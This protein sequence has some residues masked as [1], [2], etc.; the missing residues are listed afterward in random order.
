[1]TNHQDHLH[2]DTQKWPSEA[3][4]RL[5]AAW[6]VLRHGLPSQPAPETEE[7]SRTELLRLVKL[8]L[9]LTPVPPAWVD[10]ATTEELRTLAIAGAMALK[11]RESAWT[12][13]EAGGWPR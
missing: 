12:S 9:V 2:A 3:R 1:M 5:K 13:V 7:V 11:A 8:A 10:E 4:R 6:R